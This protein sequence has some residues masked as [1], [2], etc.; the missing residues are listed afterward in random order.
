MLMKIKIYLTILCLIIP[1]FSSL[2]NGQNI[3]EDNN[4]SE[5]DEL[6]E[7]KKFFKAIG[8]LNKII[9]KDP[10]NNVAYHKLGQVYNRINFYWH[11]LHYLNK[12]ITFDPFNPA[13]Y[14]DLGYLHLSLRNFDKAEIAFSKAIRIKPDYHPALY[15]MRIIFPAIDSESKVLDRI[16]AVQENY[17]NEDVSGLIS[18]EIPEKEEIKNLYVLLDKKIRLIEK[19]GSASYIIHK[20]IRI[21]SQAGLDYLKNVRQY[22]NSDRYEVFVE[23]AGTY[24]SNGK[25]IDADKDTFITITPDEISDYLMYSNS[26]Q[27]VFTLPA[28]KIG[29]T[30]EYKIRFKARNVDLSPGWNDM[31]LLSSYLPT[32][33]MKYVLRVPVGTNVKYQLQQLK[34]KPD[35]FRLKDYEIYTWQIKDVPMYKFDRHQPAFKDFAPLIYVTSEKDWDRI[36]RW[37]SDLFFSSMQ[38]TDEVSELANE[39]T[40]DKKTV[41]EKIQ[42]VYE[43][44]QKNIRY[45][46][47]E[48]GLS[49]YKPHE[50]G[51]IVKNK[52]GDC[53]DQTLFLISLLNNAGIKAYP[54]LISPTDSGRVIKDMPA[55]GHF[56]HVISYIPR[57]GNM[58]K[59]LF[60][61]TTDAITGFGRLPTG[62]QGRNVLIITDKQKG[63]WLETEV[64]TPEHNL[65][66]QE[67]DYK[68][69]LIGRGTIKLKETYKGVF[70]DSLR[71]RFNGLEEEKIKEVMKNAIIGSRNKVEFSKIWLDNLHVN[72]EPL[73]INSEYIQRDA[74][75]TYF[76][77]TLKITFNPSFLKSWF[78]FDDIAREND[79]FNPPKVMYAKSYHYQFPS[80]YSFEEIPEDKIFEND[81]LYFHVKVNNEKNNVLQIDVKGMVKEIYIPKDQYDQLPEFVKKVQDTNFSIVAVNKKSFAKD[82]FFTEL[83]AEYP[84]NDRVIESYLAY[85]LE[86][87]NNEKGIK[88]AEKAIEEFNDNLTIHFQLVEFLKRSENFAKALDVLKDLLETNENEYRVYFALSDLYEEMNELTNKVQILEKGYEKIEKN[89]IF[90]IPLSKAYSD[91]LDHEKSVVFLKKV[92]ERFPEKSEYWGQLG[93]MQSMTKDIEGAESS[94][95]QAISTDPRNANAYNNLAW[96]YCENNIKLDKALDLALKA[97]ALEPLFDTYLDTL[98]EVYFLLE[99]YDNAIKTMNKAI[100]INPNYTY[101]QHQLNKIK[102]AKRLKQKKESAE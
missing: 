93:Y 75:S 95:L 62:D 83:Y 7:Q 32:H 60:L 18:L 13:V 65:V 74:I 21:I 41:L 101:L 64:D 42:A 86:I 6:I 19:D 15:G 63:F 29:S 79:Y 4:F 36:I 76:D 67:Y 30:V 87:K 10:A 33:F 51:D 66:M 12:A 35:F 14:T 53:K 43:Y 81:Y 88:I 56:N 72:S 45:V 77:G 91:M 102:E 78:D 8:Q 2:L 23:R 34:K 98:A 25:F 70:G 27:L 26:K 90:I 61:D 47:I 31:F 97:V 50:P 17:L 22:Y 46:G 11:S 40:K 84:D 9:K 59:D 96:L 89:E 28:L 94:F 44:I 49:A 52:Y 55:L 38:I 58:K 69:D 24:D 99:D 68:I 73:I 57:S 1:L 37:Y 71:A 85:L 16:F 39:I 54:A 100:K 5:I 3:L 48:F 92:M 80:D 82:K 20:V